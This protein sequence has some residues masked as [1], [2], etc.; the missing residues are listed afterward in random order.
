VQRI[1]RATTSTRPGC[2]GAN[3]TSGCE[4]AATGT[5]HLRQ[6][7]PVSDRK[8]DLTRRAR[9][10]LPVR[11]FLASQIGLLCRRCAVPFAASSHPE[12]H[13]LLRHPGLVLVVSSNNALAPVMPNYIRFI[14][15]YKRQSLNVLEHVDRLQQSASARGRQINL[16]NVT[17]N[18]RFRVESR[19]VTNI[20]SA[21][22]LCLCAS[23]KITNESFSVRPRMKGWAQFQ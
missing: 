3:G 1:I 15:I 12:V 22:K 14:E 16:R 8:N 18:D 19:R 13:L 4:D 5:A 20:S 11:T 7:R 23:S 9:L 17:G 10:A 6:S 2:G 21:Q